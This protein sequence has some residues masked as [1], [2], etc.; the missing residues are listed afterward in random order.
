[1]LAQYYG[2]VMDLWL[3]VREW[4]GFSWIETRY[5]DVVADLPTEGA[6]VTKFLGLD[7]QE[8]QARFHQNNQHKPVM[9]TNYTAVSQP[10]YKRA[11]GRW[12]AYEK[13][14][15]QVLPMIEPYCKAFGYK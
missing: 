13:Y 15:T 6:R 9:S 10:L 1:M 4:T 12:R 11:A 3:A 8:G 2:K 7:W 5:E 14:L